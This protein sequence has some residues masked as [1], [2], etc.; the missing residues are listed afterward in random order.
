M[1]KLEKPEVK[2]LLKKNMNQRLVQTRRQHYVCNDDY[3]ALRLVA[4]MRGYD[5]ESFYKNCVNGLKYR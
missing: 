4:Q 3:D 1:I 5:Y 2:A